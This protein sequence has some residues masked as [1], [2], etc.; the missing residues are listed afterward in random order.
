MRKT[1]LPALAC[2]LG[3]IGFTGAAAANPPAHPAEHP[4][5]DHHGEQKDDAHKD[6][7]HKDEAHKDGHEAGK[8]HAEKPAH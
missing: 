3:V 5:D 2:T 8:D 4:K 1:L 6:A 7:E